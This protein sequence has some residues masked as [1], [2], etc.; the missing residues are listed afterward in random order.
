MKN[1]KKNYVPQATKEPEITIQTDGTFPNA[2]SIA[3]DSVDEHKNLEVANAIIAGDEIK[4][5]NENL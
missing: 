4:Q 3:G 2:K 5:Q 1:N